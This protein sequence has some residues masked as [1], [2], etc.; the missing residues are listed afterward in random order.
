[1]TLLEAAGIGVLQGLTEFLPVSSSAHLALAEHAIE[2]F[3]QPGRA[4]DVFLH[5]GTLLALLLYFR[6]EI[7]RLIES[8]F[9]LLAGK[10][11]G[12]AEHAANN[13]LTLLVVL[14]SV[15]TAAIGFALKDFSKEATASLP[16]MGGNLIAFG[17]LLWLA[18]RTAGAVRGQDKV[19]VA[20][21]LLMGTAQGIAVIPGISRSGVTVTAGIFRGI[22]PD[23]A[24]RL[25]FLMSIPA[26]IGAGLLE[27]R[28]MDQVPRGDL[29]AYFVGAA[30][31]AAVGLGA[32]KMLIVF[33]KGRRLWWFAL[34]RIV[35]GAVVLGHHFLF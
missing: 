26:V 33:A 25:S 11:G 32:I 9:A 24:A 31:S 22:A 18:D 7:A 3:H 28:H 23:V 12:N 14:A 17:A 35:L 4:F 13:R 29:P 27:L 5:Q 2:G 8:F 16:L 21:A 20:D 1:M 10:A 34:Y 6:A 15:P 19:S 30:V